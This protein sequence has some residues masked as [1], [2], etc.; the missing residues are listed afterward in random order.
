MDTP[1]CHAQE[2]ADYCTQQNGYLVEYHGNA[3]A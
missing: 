1:G 3:K 2:A